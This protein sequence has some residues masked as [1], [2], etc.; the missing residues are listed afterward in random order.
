MKFMLSQAPVVQPPDWA[1]PFHMFVD[2][3]DIAIR[4]AL[5]RK[6]KIS[7]RGI[8]VVC[9]FVGLALLLVVIVA[10]S[11]IL[12]GLILSVGYGCTMDGYTWFFFFGH[13]FSSA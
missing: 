4:S 6:A 1:Q 10:A 3:S 9:S 2:V 8:V 13:L 11:T 12:V 5:M 7:S